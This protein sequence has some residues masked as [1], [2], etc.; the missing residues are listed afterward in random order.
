MAIK[1]EKVFLKQ[2][3]FSIFNISFK[4]KRSIYNRFLSIINKSIYNKINITLYT[5]I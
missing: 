3:T 4:R 5:K 2:A 1:I